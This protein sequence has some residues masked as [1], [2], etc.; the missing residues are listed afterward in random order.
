[1]AR[2]SIMPVLAGGK[3]LQ[4]F[5]EEVAHIA[6]EL[7]DLCGKSDHLQLAALAQEANFFVSDC[8]EE[9]HLA[10]STGCAG[11]LIRKADKKGHTPSGRHVMTLTADRNLGEVAPDFVWQCLDNMGLLSEKSDIDYASAS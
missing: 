7:V 8:A 10:V 5:G 3:Q 1:M 9:V 6:P 4:A 11:V 2:A